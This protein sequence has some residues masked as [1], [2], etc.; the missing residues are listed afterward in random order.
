MTR[1]Y[2]TA[3]KKHDSNE[4]SRSS[5]LEKDKTT[6]NKHETKLGN[7]K[8]TTTAP[9]LGVGVEPKICHLTDT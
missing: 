2:S 7:K 3:T 6:D 9:Q 4:N 5:S 8:T 1:S